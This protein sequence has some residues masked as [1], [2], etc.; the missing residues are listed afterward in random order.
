MIAHSAFH[1]TGFSSPNGTVVPD[2][3]FDVLAPNLTE[4][5]L[6]VLLYIIRRTFGFKKESDQISLKQMVEGIRTKEGKVLDHGAGVAKSAAARAIHGLVEKGI[7][8]VSRNRTRERGDVA[9]TYTLRFK[10]APVSCKRTR[11]GPAKGQGGVLQKNTQQTVLQQTDLQSSNNRM[12]KPK[13]NKT[14]DESV[15]MS[16]RTGNSREFETVA[17]I[18]KR[19]QLQTT[20]SVTNEDREVIATYIQELAGELNDQASLTASTSRAVN[21][22]RRAGVP[23]AAFINRLYEARAIVKERSSQT[24]SQPARRKMAY[25]FACLEDCLRLGKAGPRQRIITDD[26]RERATSKRR[27]GIQWGNGAAP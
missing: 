25:F 24:T 4:A 10:D 11:G 22:F 3:V 14:R 19:E 7:I 27:P 26:P 18:L 8:T 2:D 16:R 6:R 23:L 21:L 13:E 20:P 1:Y 17:V 5:E 12:V 9:T 15:R